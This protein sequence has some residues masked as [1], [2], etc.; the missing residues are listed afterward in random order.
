MK[1]MRRTI[2]PHQIIKILICFINDLSNI[3]H[4][5]HLSLIL[6][7]EIEEIQFIYS[8]TAIDESIKCV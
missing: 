4:T 1:R 8:I 5:K 2:F 3:C 7:M 6:D